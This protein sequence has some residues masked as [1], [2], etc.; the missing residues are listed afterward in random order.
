MT[1]RPIPFS[2]SAFFFGLAPAPGRMR[3]SWRRC[4]KNPPGQGAPAA[5]ALCLGKS[6][7]DKPH[8]GPGSSRDNA[9]PAPHPAPRS[10]DP[11]LLP[12]LPQP[13][14]CPESRSVLCPLLPESP[15]A[16]ARRWGPH[17]AGLGFNAHSSRQGQQFCSPHLLPSLR[18]RK[19]PSPLLVPHSASALFPSPVPRPRACGQK[20]PGSSGA[21]HEKGKSEGRLGE[22]SSKKD[23]ARKTQGGGRRTCGSAERK[24]AQARTTPRRQ[25]TSVRN[26]RKRKFKKTEAADQ[27]RPAASKNAE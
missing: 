12:A 13:P 27:R 7:R 15:R 14:H 18:L 1:R 19:L 20:S 24:S 5:A 25:Q 11:R 21:K 6:P 8:Q 10:R 4:N 26:E 23:E 3:G 17:P 16:G 22:G 9:L 2:G